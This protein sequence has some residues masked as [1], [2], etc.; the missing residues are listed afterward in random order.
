MEKSLFK[1]TNEEDTL[2]FDYCFLKLVF[3]RV[4]NARAAHALD[5]IVEEQ[6]N[7]RRIGLE[8]Q[9]NKVTDNFSQ[10]LVIDTP[11]NW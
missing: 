7:T 3:H 1:Y 2:V 11:R 6:R 8:I 5:P 9:S 10:K 4:Y